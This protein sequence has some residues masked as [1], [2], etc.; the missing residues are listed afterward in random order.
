[1]NS[2]LQYRSFGLSLLFHALLIPAFVISS[3]CSSNTPPKPPRL[4]VQ[5]IRLAAPSRTVIQ[6]PPSPVHNP[7]PE[8]PA[9]SVDESIAETTNE[10]QET[11]TPPAEPEKAP[12][13][14]DAQKTKPTPQVKLKKQVSSSKSVQQKTTKSRQATSSQ[15]KAPS[16]NKKLL[17]EALKSLDRSKSR[18][19][20]KTAAATTS[21]RVETVG[22]LNVDTGISSA[23][24]EGNEGYPPASPEDYYITDLIRRLQLNIRLPEPGEVKLTLTLNRNGSVSAV[25][26]LKCKKDAL[27][28][29]ISEKLRT[30]TFSAFG[31]GFKGEQYHTFTLR[32]SNDFS[33]ACS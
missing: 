9:P 33:W 15:A 22:T 25:T 8:S 32:L 10:Q 12:P 2:T 26:I 11:P 30:L 1:M 16:Y 29:N 31:N 6:A 24:E 13:R 18:T 7:P 21:R 3:F 20:T 27:K 17:D 19:G 28:K 23:N 4:L 5:S 14:K